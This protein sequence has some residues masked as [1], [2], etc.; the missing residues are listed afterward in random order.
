MNG[1]RKL[2]YIHNGVLLSQKKNEIMSFAGRW[3]E[4]E[5]IILSEINQVQKDKDHMFSLIC[6]SLTYKI[7]VY[8]HDHIYVKHVYNNG[9]VWGDH[10]EAE[11][12]KDRVN[13]TEIHCIWVWRCRKHTWKAVV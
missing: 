3:K 11:E 12:E 9:S 7:N 10:A 1:L 4:R 8:T 2:V 5:T 6:G 13:N